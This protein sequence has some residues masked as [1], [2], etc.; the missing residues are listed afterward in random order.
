MDSSTF[1]IKTNTS[2]NFTTSNKYIKYRIIVTENSINTDTNKSNITVKVQ[3]W[4]TNTGYTTYGSGTC[5][6]TIDGTTYNQAIT[7]SQK[8]TYNSYTEVF[9]RTLDVEHE[10]NGTKTIYVS[11]YI[12]HDRFTSNTQGFNVKLTDIPRQAN[13]VSAPNFTDEENPTIT[14]SNSA[15]DEVTTLQACISLTGST[16]DIEYRDI[17]KTGTSYTFNLTTAERNVLRAAAANTKTLSVIFYIKTILNGTTFYSTS[18]K[19]MTIVNANPT[20]EEI[21]YQDTNSTI[22]ALTENNQLIVRN[23]STLQINL[24]NLAAL[25]KATLSS[26]KVTI[27]GITKNFT[28]ITGTTL[29][30]ATLNFGTLNVSSNIN[31]SIV[32]TDSRGNSTTYTKAIQ[33]LNYESPYF[34][35]TLQRN[36]NFYSETNLNVD[37]SY[38]S[39]NGKNNITIQYQTKKATEASYGALTTIQNNTDTEIVLDNTYQWYVKVIVTDLLNTTVNQEV[40]LNKGIPFKFEDRLLNSIGFNCFP[41]NENSVESEGLQLDDLIYIGNQV[42]YDELQMTT[43]SKQAVLGSYNYD[44]VQGVFNGI[45]IPE[46]YERAYRLTAQIYTLNNNLGSVWINNIQS[47]KVNTWAGY[48]TMR[49]IAST[50]IFKESELE[51]EP[52][53]NYSARQGT[54]LYCDNSGDYQANFYNITIHGYLVK[55]ST[56]LTAAY[57]DEGGD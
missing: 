16:D 47:S 33:I 40:F 17:S 32:L 24:S 50:R 7:S 56:T 29:S 2:G 51:L 31:A 22:T 8:F 20:I 3:V 35:V 10:D 18:R 25:K 5:Y 23:K 26:A 21:T 43:E 14:Y 55:K 34:T 30:S 38:S 57:L 44:L 48:T 11:S 9:S 53:Y 54:N 46:A 42:L 1:V 52:T 28:G 49:K 27:N 37:C 19:T 45:N 4:R 41:V 13:I 6:C 15:G 36:N 12:S 39:L